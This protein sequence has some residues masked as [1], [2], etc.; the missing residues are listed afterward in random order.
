LLMQLGV[1]DLASQVDRDKIAPFVGVWGR[2]GI[3]DRGNC[4]D[5]L[6]DAGS[7]RGQIEAGYPGVQYKD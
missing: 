5:Y 2:D 3:Q 1:Q 7:S 4:A 6:G